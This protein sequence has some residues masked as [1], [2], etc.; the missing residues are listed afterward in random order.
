MLVPLR[1][2]RDY[3]DFGLGANELADL[4]TM[5]GTKVEAVTKTAERMSGIISAKVEEI[6]PH[7][8]DPR[9]RV[10][11]LWTPHYSYTVVTAANNVQQGDM[12][13]L[14]APG[15]TLHDGRKIG[16]VEFTG[17]VSE[18]MM[19]SSMELGIS[20]DADGILILSESFLSGID[21]V[22]V[23][24]LQ[25]DVLELEITP[26][27]PDCLGMLG[28]AREVAAITRTA[29]KWPSND[30]PAEGDHA[31]DMTMAEV[32]DP[33][34]CSRY[35]LKV[36]SD[37]KIGPS[38]LW[39]Q[40]RL[41]AAGIR[42]ISNVVDVTNYV[43]LDV[44]QPLHAFDY[45]R[46]EGGRI[47]VRR[48]KDGESIKTLDGQER[49]V[50]KGMLLIC[51]AVKPVAVAGV[52]GGAESEIG[53]S[54]RRVLLESA[55]FQRQS[56]WRTSKALKLRTES[57]SRFEK[58][59]DTET[60]PIALERSSSLLAYMG[61]ARINP[62]IVDVNN[63]VWTGK[64][65]STTRSWISKSLGTELGT[66]VD[67]YLA[68]L[69]MDI[70][71]EGQGGR[72][73]VRIPSW[74][75]DLNEPI[76]LV[77]EVARLHGYN[78]LESE[79]PV[80]LKPSDW[81]YEQKAEKRIK[82]LLTGLSLHETSTYSLVPK[83]DTLKMMIGPDETASKPITVMNPLSEDQSSLRTML[84]PSLLRVIST[85]LRRGA[86]SAGFFEL[87]RIYL[88][89]D[90]SLPEG[91]LPRG[92][93]PCIERKMIAAAISGNSGDRTWHAP[94][95]PYDFFDIKG[96]IES[97]FTSLGIEDYGFRT[98]E[99]KYLMPGRRA[100]VVVCGKKVG[101]LGQLH[102]D[103]AGSFDVPENTLV[104]EMEVEA[105]MDVIRKDMKFAGIP[106]HPSTERDI[107]ML[108]PKEV[109]ADSVICFIRR[110]G[111]SVVESV[112]VFDQYEGTNIKEGTKSLA[113]TVKYRAYDR[114]LTSDE[115]NEIHERVREGLVREL[116]AVLR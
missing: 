42:P 23:L 38:P 95:R 67:E 22:S 74:R 107:A 32:M 45:D 16:T 8:E 21:M 54:T 91:E 80:N 62:G 19:C 96:I 99:A 90:G 72:L 102:P 105:I 61:A 29:L 63:N 12:V 66:K 36:F 79:V 46:L 114:T 56:V 58:G 50:E 57:S 7:P 3:V 41:R 39:M 2:L 115:V 11:K 70:D 4:L 113:F 44:N 10:A 94:E 75:G 33:D 52:M 110:T 48:A 116:G 14:A 86:R 27:R 13:P 89:E 98:G 68:L 87:A 81:T 37:V 84:I 6:H 83:D 28:V 47:I 97:L 65:I 76:D 78:N 106:K 103:V 71:S 82:N 55:T 77:E 100:E 1:W 60:V 69:G 93:K 64:S 112:V 73:T 17:I 25:D 109:T 30:Y 49:P 24:E 59:L 31:A 35:A 9:L 104:F 92:Q 85:N 20:D 26:N 18:G 40:V 111:G 108:L 43:M 5:T 101:V 15:A 53:E 51:D 88:M 34:L